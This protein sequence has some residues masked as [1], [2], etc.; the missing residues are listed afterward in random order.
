VT[1][2]EGHGLRVQLPPRFEARI[3]RHPPGPG[4][5]TYPVAH[6][7]TMP[8]PPNVGDTG[9]GALQLLGTRDAFVA[10]IEYG[11]E[12]A[13]RRMFAGK[14]LPRRLEPDVFKPYRSR[15]GQPHHSGAQFFFVESGR[16]FTLYIVL[17]S[18]LGRRAV[19]P[20]VDALLQGIE[21]AA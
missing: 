3:F 19:L 1:V 8:I 11:P 17:G 10:L 14:V 18:H 21:V 7:A 12:S 20:T 6:F 16:P 5:E 4:E 15:S 9:N 2:L 13:D